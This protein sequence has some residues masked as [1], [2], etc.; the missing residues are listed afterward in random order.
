MSGRDGLL[1]RKDIF[2]GC[3][4]F[5][6]PKFVIDAIAAGREGAIQLERDL[7]EASNMMTREEGKPKGILPYAAKRAA[8]IQI[9]NMQA[10]REK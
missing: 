1:S 10:K 4:V 3:A 6:G 2:A 9:K 8:K 7:P 5:T